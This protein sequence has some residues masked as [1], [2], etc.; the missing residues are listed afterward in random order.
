M[1]M[2]PVRLMVIFSKYIP[3]KIV[4]CNDRD[5]LWITSKVKTAI[6]RNPRVYRKWA[7]RGGNL[8][9]S[10]EVDE[11]QDITSKLIKMPSS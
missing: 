6:I 1:P 3:N 4:T 7:K 11:F 9:D 8:N 2:A 10:E 5:V